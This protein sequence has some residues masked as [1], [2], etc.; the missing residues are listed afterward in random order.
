MSCTSTIGSCPVCQSIWDARL[1]G[2]TWIKTLVS[3]S[4]VPS[5]TAQDWTMQDGDPTHMA[6][7]VCGDNCSSDGSCSSPVTP[8]DPP[9]PNYCY[10]EWHAEWVCPGDGS[11]P[12]WELSLGGSATCTNCSP[13][14]SGWSSP[15]GNPATC[16]RY[17]C[18]EICSGSC[19]PATP[20]AP[21]DLGY[22]CGVCDEHGC[23]G[24]QNADCPDLGGACSVLGTYS[25]ITGG[26]RWDF[27]G[28]SFNFYLTYVG[29]VFTFG[30]VC[31]SATQSI[32]LVCDPVTGKLTGTAVITLDGTLTGCNI[33]TGPFQAHLTFPATGC[34]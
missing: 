34:P 11:T 29:G 32:S 4:C 13:S 5:C 19:S 12:H 21:A 26:C 27:T 7:V 8:A 22:T 10:A 20:D 6:C 23:A 3:S 15:T 14:D 17:I 1:S 25:A 28:A 16:T 18:A 9:M 30:G 31:W 33:P 24:N 2:S